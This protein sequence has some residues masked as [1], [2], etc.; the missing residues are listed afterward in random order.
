M[1][2]KNKNI[3]EEKKEEKIKKNKGENTKKRKITKVT[4]K[5]IKRVKLDAPKIPDVDLTVKKQEKV[6]KKYNIST[7][8]KSKWKDW[9]EIYLV[10]FI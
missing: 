6:E 2:E 1:E 8:E 5:I 3:E 4:H 9:K 7:V 10:I